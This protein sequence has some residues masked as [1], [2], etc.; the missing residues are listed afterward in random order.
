LK[1]VAITSCP[2]GI[3]HTYMAAEALSIAASEMGHEI[4]VETHGSIGI[5]NIITEEDLSDAEAVIIAADIHVDQSRVHGLPVPQ[6]SV[7]ETLKDA[8]GLISKALE[9]EKVN[10]KNAQE[11]TKEPELRTKNTAYN[12]IMLGVSY[13]IPFIVIIGVFTCLS[14]IFEQ[15][16]F[17]P[18]AFLASLF[19]LVGTESALSIILPVFAAY[20]SFS[21]AD[22]PG[23]A[24]GF[25]GGYLCQ[26]LGFGFLAGLL[27][28]FLAGYTVYYLNKL[29]KLPKQIDSLMPGIILPVLSTFIV[30]L[31]IMYASALPLREVS[32]YLDLYI[33][34]VTGVPAIL[35][36]IIL[37]AMMGFDLGGPV[38]KIAYTF[39]LATIAAGQQSTYMAAVMA[40]GMTPPLGMALAATF[41]SSKFNLQERESVKAAWILGITFITEGALPF[42]KEDKSRV[43]YSIMT[44]SAVA[45]AVSMAFGCTLAVPHGGIFVLWIPNVTSRLLSYLL[46]IVIGTIVTALMTVIFKNTISTEIEK[47]R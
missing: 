33:H 9:M 35:T 17:L 15:E 14:F 20:I 37:G 16:A 19:K 11:K 44:G 32:N 36:A 7:R 6:V 38:N 27:I 45:A 24:P 5:E 28:G 47:T 21:I 31:A 46:S 34:S 18:N 40:A 10:V 30:T 4:K 29:I 42:I 1:L 8:K 26:R 41:A 13:I 3:A 12:H 23:L 43:R 25:M 39:A 22:K 2:S